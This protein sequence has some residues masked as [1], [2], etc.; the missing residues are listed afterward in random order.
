LILA[1]STRR[2][3][4]KCEGIKNIVL[5]LEK[6]LNLETAIQRGRQM[7][8]FDPERVAAWDSIPIG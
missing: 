5:S 7:Q 6:Q 4:E 1:R 8:S 3:Q 2:K